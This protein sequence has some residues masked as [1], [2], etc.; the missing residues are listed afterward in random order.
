MSDYDKEV[1]T[2]SALLERLDTIEANV[3]NIRNNFV[4]HTRALETKVKQLEDR[5]QTQRDESSHSEAESK[6]LG[7]RLNAIELE[8]EVMNKVVTKNALAL[9][10]IEERIAI[11]LLYTSPSPRD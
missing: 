11:C 2:A 7:Y 5:A 1:L 6:V 9:C 8:V 10:E 4:G 3:S